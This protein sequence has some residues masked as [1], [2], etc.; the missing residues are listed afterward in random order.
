VSAEVPGFTESQLKVSV[1]PRHLIITGK[2]EPTQKEDK[3]RTVHA[4]ECASEIFRFIELPA[5]VNAAKMSAKLKDGVLTL[6]IPKVEK[7]KAMRQ[8]QAA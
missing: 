1:Q 6:S 4:D 3:G 2:R 8:A 7:V 5:E